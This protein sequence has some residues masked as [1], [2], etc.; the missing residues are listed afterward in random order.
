MPF[1]SKAQVR[2]LFATEPKV[3]K[4]FAAKTPNMKSLPEKAAKDDWHTKHA[5]KFRR[6]AMKNR[7]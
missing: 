6:N 3:A 2:Y 1:A 4:E 7:K 5:D